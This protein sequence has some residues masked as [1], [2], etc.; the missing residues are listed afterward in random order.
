MNT[1]VWCNKNSELIIWEEWKGKK[2]DIFEEINLH[3]P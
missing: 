3:L 1:D 2:Q